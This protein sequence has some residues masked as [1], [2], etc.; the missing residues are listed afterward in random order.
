MTN[1]YYNHTDA[2]PYAPSAGLSRNVHNEFD[3]VAT[4]FGLVETAIA[5]APGTVTSV[6]ASVPAF[7][8][9]AGSP[10][11][12]SGTLAISY[13]GTALPVANGGTGDT[14]L[15]AYAP[16]FGGTTTTG[17]VQSGTVGTSGHVL[18]SNGAGAIATFQAAAGGAST[19]A[20]NVFTKNQSVTAV[21]LTSTSNLTAVDA[22][23]SNNFEMT[24]SENTTISN[25]TNM[26]GGMQLFFR[27]KQHASAAKT[28][29]FGSKFK[30]SSLDA[31]T[32]ATG[33]GAVCIMS[34]YY[35][36]GDDRLECVFN[37]GTGFA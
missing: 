32:M 16:L 12:G 34:C 11:T 37:G 15:T 14:S 7:L 13:S 29:A 1:S 19:S 30:F 5:A 17:P 27:I 22:S 35:N 2:S 10:I 18:T 9:V 23:L 20:V 21:T 25:P 3:K 4:G 36:S 31:H 24:L 8:S 6:A 33:L 26:T 28:L